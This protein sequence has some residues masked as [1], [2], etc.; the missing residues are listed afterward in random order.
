[1]EQSNQNQI[2][3]EKTNWE[4]I[5]KL[6]SEVQNKSELLFKTSSDNILNRTSLFILSSNLQ[7]IINNTDLQNIQERN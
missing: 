2:I 6:T 1:M 4:N 3:I 7:N 5:I